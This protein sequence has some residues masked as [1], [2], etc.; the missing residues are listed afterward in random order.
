[1]LHDNL[2]RTVMWICWLALGATVVG[3]LSA[4]CP[5]PSSQIRP[6]TAAAGRIIPGQEQPGAVG[7]KAGASGADQAANRGA[8]FVELTTRE[9]FHKSVSSSSR[10]GR[11]PA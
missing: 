10:R 1:M 4:G 6:P 3:L 11:S 2:G 5:G 8:N 7:G 9:E